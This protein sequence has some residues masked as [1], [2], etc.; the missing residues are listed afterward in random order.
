MTN[1][2]ADAS[3]A[4]DLDDV[5]R[6]A[7]RL[8]GI[9]VRTPVIQVP[10]LDA[11][12]GASVFLKAENLQRTG[13]FKFRGGYNSISALDADERA[14][15]VVAFSSGNHAQAV[16]CAAAMCGSTSVIVMPHD[17]PP[18]KMSATEGYGAEIV[19]YDRYTEDR[20]EIAAAIRDEQGRV[21]I[22]PFDHPMV[23]AGQGTAA[24]ELLDQV[25]ELDALFV[26]LG[27]GGLLAGCSTVMNALLPE[28]DVYGVE[29]ATGNDHILSK[30][31]GQRISIDVPKTIAD[32]QQTTTP[33]VLTWAINREN[34]SDF[35]VVSDDEIVAT[36]RS[37]FAEAKLVVEPSGASALAA[38]LHRD[39]ASL[40]LSGGRI[41]VTISGGNIGWDR[42]ASLV[43]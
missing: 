36:M 17:A 3:K 19:R 35:L 34:A 11:Q 12:V 23:M 32:G 18:E 22:P 5:Y 10:A 1:D 9:A 16:A 6:A 38:V 8:D 2:P 43:G 7:E 31:A 26:C 33:G 15:G 29:P 27:G 14:A 25:G 37:L 13:A 4:I 40:G 30:A 24:L 21:L 20:A 39:I 28:A 41:G 42:F